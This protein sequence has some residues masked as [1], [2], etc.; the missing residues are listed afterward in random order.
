MQDRRLFLPLVMA[1]V[2]Q[3]PACKAREC[4]GHGDG[5]F[6]CEG[7]TIMQCRQGFEYVFGTCEPNICFEGS[8]ALAGVT[9]PT[10]RLGYQCLDERRVE[11]LANGMVMDDGTCSPQTD[12]QS[13]AGKGPY[14]VENPGGQILPCGW[15]RQKCTNEGEVDCFEDG[16][17]VCRQ[18]VYQ[19]FLPNDK[20]TY[21]TCVATPL[22]SCWGGKT[23]CDGDVLKRCD[24]CTD[25]QTCAS[26]TIEA[27][28]DTGACA[29]YPRPRWM[30]ESWVPDDLLYGCV[31]D[32]PACVG[33]STMACVDGTAAACVGNGKAVAGLSCAEIQLF[34]GGHPLS[35]MGTKYGPVCVERSG[36]GDAICAYDSAPC[37]ADEETRCAPSDA[38]TPSVDICRDG[39]WLF[40]KSCV[41]TD[42]DTTTCQSG[43]SRGFCQ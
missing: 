38:S 6:W 13:L 8:C 7:Q 18:G 20:A 3:V 35:S 1:A 39:V 23:W 22:A 24:R 21:A 40:R 36:Q 11:C 17:A 37:A 12:W 30:V 2:C 15:K 19:D 32:C 43:V 4:P 33:G 31:V 16:S 27:I 28:C 9:C 42:Y 29:A 26:T 14:C 5:A 25:A 34:L 41:S 10:D